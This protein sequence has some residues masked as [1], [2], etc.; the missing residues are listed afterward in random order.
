MV[1][2]AARMVVEV[3]VLFI[4]YQVVS[5]AWSRCTSKYKLDILEA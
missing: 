1:I 4:Q 5:G 2:M 3:M